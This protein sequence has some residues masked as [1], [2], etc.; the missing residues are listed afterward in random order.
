MDAARGFGLPVSSR[1]T[2]ASDIL[3]FARSMLTALR[4]PA[5]AGQQRRLP[6][7][8]QPSRPTPIPIKARSVSDGITFD[9]ARGFGLPVSSRR[10][11]ASDILSFARSMLTALRHPACAGQQRRLPGHGQPSRP[12]PIPIKARSVSDGITFD[13]AWPF[14]LPVPVARSTSAARAPGTEGIGGGKKLL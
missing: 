4:H 8:G 1:R 9:T 7:H 12:T 2:L 11:L 6:G 14:G 5:C 13:T 10:T 3:S